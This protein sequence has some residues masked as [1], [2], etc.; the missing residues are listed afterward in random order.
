M[1]FARLSGGNCARARWSRQPPQ[2]GSSQCPQRTPSS[3]CPGT[4]RQ[5]WSSGQRSSSAP[6]GPGSRKTLRVRQLLARDVELVVFLQKP[7][8]ADTSRRCGRRLPEEEALPR[9]LATQWP[10]PLDLALPLKLRHAGVD[11]GAAEANQSFHA[12]LRSRLG[13][14]A[15]RGAIQG[16]PRQRRP[17]P[18]APGDGLVVNAQQRVR[19]AR[20]RKA[21]GGGL[22]VFRMLRLKVLGEVRFQAVGRLPS[23]AVKGAERAGPDRPSAQHLRR[24]AGASAGT[25]ASAP[26]PSPRPLGGGRGGKSGPRDHEGFA[27]FLHHIV[28]QLRR[29]RCLFP[30]AAP[31][32]CRSGLGGPRRRAANPAA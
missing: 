28:L 10:P 4:A 24:P 26:T 17:G 3:T 1:S 7:L 20:P 15:Q 27:D 13:E 32:L 9:R 30:E 6:P 8:Q 23:A 21:S 31:G 16:A 19:G 2:T 5:R 29:R 18:A 25:G 14:G 22:Q 12:V 11:A